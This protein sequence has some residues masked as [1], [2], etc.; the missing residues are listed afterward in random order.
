ML[1]A[2]EC[3][4]AMMICVDPLMEWE[5]FGFSPALFALSLVLLTAVS[6]GMSQIPLSRLTAG[7]FGLI[8][9]SIGSAG[10][11]AAWSASWIH[12]LRHHPFDG[13]RLGWWMLWAAGISAAAGHGLL[14]SYFGVDRSRAVLR[15]L[16]TAISAMAAVLMWMPH[17]RTSL[18]LPAVIGFTGVAISFVNTKPQLLPSV[19]NL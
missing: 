17:E 1:I 8:L 7:R 11:M 14:K 16:V 4:I 18:G 19:S 2:V 12:T 15:G 13:Q 9:L 6:M 5:T 3:V 10:F